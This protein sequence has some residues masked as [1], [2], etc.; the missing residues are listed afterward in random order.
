VRARLLHEIGTIYIGLGDTKAAAPLCDEALKLRRKLLPPDHP[1]LARSIHRVALLRYLDGDWSCLD[2]FREAIA[3]L[4]KQPDPE[5][6]E[7]AEA[8]SALGLSVNL[9][10]KKQAIELYTHALKIRRAR[11]GEY[12]LQT[13]STLFLLVN[14][15]LEL[16]DYVRGMALASE[17]S[18]SGA[19]PTTLSRSGRK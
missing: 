3:I 12:D 19:Q 10:D 6:L 1:D 14:A 7:L 15:H 17:R 8:E 4:K 9:F 18:L 13:L 11:L 2:L 16:R 5:S